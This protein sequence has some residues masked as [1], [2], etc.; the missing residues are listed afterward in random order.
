MTRLATA[1]LCTL[2]LLAC[3]SLDRLRPQ[4]PEVTLAGIRPVSI[5]LFE[6]IFEVDLR[7][8]NPNSFELPIEGLEYTLRVRDEKVAR[9]GSSEAVTLP[10]HESRLVTVSAVGSLFGLLQLLR[11]QQDT[12]FD[13]RLEGSVDV[14]G[15]PGRVNFDREGS[16][17]LGELAGSQ[18]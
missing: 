18:T 12:A 1:L 11:K 6:Q 16:L 13:Y 4:A 14:G 5:S 9:G 15:V 8:H 3:T 7:V 17:D 2:L 10:P